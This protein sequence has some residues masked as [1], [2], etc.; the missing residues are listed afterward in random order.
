MGKSFNTMREDDYMKVSRKLARQVN[1]NDKAE[2]QASYTREDT[3][4][5]RPARQARALRKLGW[6]V[7]VILLSL[8]IA[9]PGVS[10]WGAH[11]SSMGHHAGNHGHTGHGSGHTSM[12]SYLTGG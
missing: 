11:G 10:A 8:A 5:A 4:Q 2:R 3:H 9:A 7:I 6:Q 12:R 1:A